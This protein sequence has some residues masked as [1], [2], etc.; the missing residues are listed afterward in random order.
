MQIMEL[1]KKNIK[2]LDIIT[3]EAIEN[4]IAVDLSIGASSNSV[5]HLTAIAHEAGIDFDIN[6]FAEM[7]KKVP[8]LMK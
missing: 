5:L 1:Y 4:A 6:T 7:A 3:K 8:H 2:P